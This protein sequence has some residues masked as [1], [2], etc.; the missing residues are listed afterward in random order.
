MRH[1]SQP[2]RRPPLKNKFVS[3]VPGAIGYVYAGDTDDSVK[4]IKIDGVGP[5]GAGYKFALK[6]R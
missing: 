1:P 5:D 2:F 4:I 3:L 6:G